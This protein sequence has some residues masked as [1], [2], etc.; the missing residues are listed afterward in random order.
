[1]ADDDG[2]EAIRR[3]RA[4]AQ[5]DAS[6]AAAAARGSLVDVDELLSSCAPLTV[7]ADQN[8]NSSAR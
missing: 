2:P 7:C 5:R 4:Q 3:R 8:G 1:L 6:Y